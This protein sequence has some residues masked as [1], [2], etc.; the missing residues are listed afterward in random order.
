MS[1]TLRHGAGHRHLAP[2][3]G[4]RHRGSGEVCC[5]K[6]RMIS[7]AFM[8]AG[9]LEHINQYLKIQRSLLLSFINTHHVLSL[10]RKKVCG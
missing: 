3:G 2:S 5:F 9:Y 8:T 1:L 10:C 7:A 4:R 6:F